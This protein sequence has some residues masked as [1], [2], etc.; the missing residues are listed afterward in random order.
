MKNVS[1]LPLTLAHLIGRPVHTFPEVPIRRHLLFH[2]FYDAVYGAIL[3]HMK[4]VA[5]LLWVSR[6]SLRV[7]DI[8]TFPGSLNGPLLDL[9]RPR[10]IKKFRYPKYLG[11][12]VD[13]TNL[14]I[15]RLA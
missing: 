8:A 2:S 11:N 10:Y 6:L 14:Y 1:S 13:I 9:Y 5:Y 4:P 7:R 12:T 3:F 15:I